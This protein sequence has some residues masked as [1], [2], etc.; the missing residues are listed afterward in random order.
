MHSY[1]KIKI[2]GGPQLRP[3]INIKDVVR[4]YEL[5]LAAP[6]DKINGDIFNAGYQNR[7]VEELATIIK[8][9]IDDD[10]ITFENVPTDD[11]R[12][13]HINSDKIHKVL[14]FKQKYTIE[15]G[16]QSLVDAYEKGLIIDG[17]NNPMYYNIKLM[18]KV[19][20]K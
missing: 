20:L 4:M 6:S 10:S 12:S 14:G 9:V 5:L 8:K 3:N 15:D 11:I 1:K 2:F 18:Q 16:V 13:Y 19:D 17:L 7:T